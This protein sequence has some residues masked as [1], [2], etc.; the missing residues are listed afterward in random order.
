MERDEG[1]GCC[2]S[3]VNDRKRSDDPVHPTRS[4]LSCP[5]VGGVSL[6]LSL[7]CSAAR[8][9]NIFLSSVFLLVL[10]ILPGRHRFEIHMRSG[11]DCTWTDK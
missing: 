6:S 3:G 7:A 4:L 10:L 11:F 5:F 9:E 2:S 8:A 1:A